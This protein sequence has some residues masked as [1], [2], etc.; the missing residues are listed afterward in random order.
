MPAATSART[1]GELCARL[2]A[3]VP[4][5]VEA[6]RRS[7]CDLRIQSPLPSG[8]S[9]RSRTLTVELGAGRPSFDPGPTSSRGLP[10]PSRFGRWAL[11][12]SAWLL[13]CIGAGLVVALF[14]CPYARLSWCWLGCCSWCRFGRC[15]FSVSVCSPVLVWLGCCSWCRL[16][17]CAFSVS[18]CSLACLG[19]GLL[20][21]SPAPRRPAGE[22]HRGWRKADPAGAVVARHAPV[23]T[24]GRGGSSRPNSG[25]CQRPRALIMPGSVSGVRSGVG[26]NAIT[27]TVTPFAA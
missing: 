18:A 24:V 19:A 11:S 1:D 8:R 5:N 26:S 13:A 2:L 17:H 12:V 4:V 21:G 25:R 9:P 10:P 14:R 15:A 6:G 20:V 27:G 7:C 3:A 22:P 23:A 16:G